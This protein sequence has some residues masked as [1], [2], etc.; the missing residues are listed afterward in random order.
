LKTLRLWQAIAAT[1]A[2]ALHCV[3]VSADPASDF[4]D[5]QALGNARKSEGVTAI[6][7]GTAQATDPNY[8]TTPPQ[9]SYY[10]KANLSLQTTLQQATCTANPAD[11]SCAAAALGT[12]VK[13]KQYVTTAD[14]ALAGSLAAEDPSVILGNI[15]STY[16]AC[17]SD[18]K[19]LSPAT[20]S[21]SSC[22]VETGA[23]VTNTC[24]KTLTVAP[25]DKF[26]C[27]VG[28]VASQVS[29]GWDYQN[30]K[31]A[32]LYINGGVARAYCEPGER[33][34]LHM[35]FF[36]GNV[37]EGDAGSG[38]D[39]GPAPVASLLPDLD[40]VQLPIN[41]KEDMVLPKSGITILAGSG[42]NWQGKCNFN[43]KRGS[44]TF[45]MAFLRPDIERIPGDYWAN[46]CEAFE[47]QTVNATLP[48][49]GSNLP[50]SLVLP[51]ISNTATNQCTRTQSTCVDGPSTKV[52][53]GI[54]VTRQCWK[55]DNTFDCTSLSATSTC[56][57]QAFGKCSQAGPV[58]CLLSDNAGHCLSA[59]VDFNCKTTSATY[60]PAL[61]CGPSTFCPGGSCYD[62][63][64]PPDADFAQTVTMLEA[65]REAGG[66]VDPKNLKVF[67]GF[68]NRCIKKLFGLVNCCKGGGTGS[69]AAFN[70]LSVAAS[71]VGAVGSAAF[72]SYTYN[73]LFTSEA[74]NLVI[75][76]FEAL[77]GTGLD[78]G[79]AGV[80]AGDLSVSGFLTSLVPGPWTLAMLAIQFSGML[81]CPKEAQTTA[82]KR[83]ANLCHSI[84]DF[85]SS[86]V[87]GVCQEK[88]QTYCCYTSRLAKIINQKVRL[89][90]AMAWGSAEKPQCG[91]FSVAELQALDFSKL[92]MTEFYAEIVPSLPNLSDIQKDAL[93]KKTTCYYGA[94]KC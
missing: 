76:G 20:F 25:K 41:I 85:C 6:K 9:T 53:D 40:D 60:G 34:V 65:G 64:A 58:N 24:S 37:N 15:A 35:G 86:K 79:L 10:G 42:C 94:G 31:G 56:N 78:S 39:F 84:G 51:A 52:I 91:G 38:S 26:N 32:D 16:S 11:P 27:T 44:R 63:T 22:K 3:A 4:A 93:A 50:T 67:V 80:I 74:P 8:N 59:K 43:M 54:E 69:A 68:D 73:A 83:D 70:D 5:G 48:P 23:W 72:S 47:A 36:G 75:Q 49:D 7:S 13:P 17:A 18:T 57:D 45:S 62:K 19:L 30:R 2:L 89:T 82:M 28:G 90:S 61:N 29:F 87:L 12:K 33:T 81:D 46:D 77:F 66:G 55:Y 14:K 1:T 88:T 92:D 21:V 71:A